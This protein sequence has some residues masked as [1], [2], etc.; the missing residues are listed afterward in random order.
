VAIT[1]QVRARLGLPDTVTTLTPNDAIR[2]I[3][4]APVDLLWNGGIGTYVKATDERHADVGDKTNDALR[5]DAPELRCRVVAEGGNLGLTQAARVEYALDEGRVNTDFIDNSGGVDASDH[6]VNI[7]IV[8]DAAVRNGNLTHDERDRLLLEMTDDVTALVLRT[9]YRQNRAI[10]NSASQ[11]PSMEDVHARYIRELEHDGILDRALESLPD[12]EAL[13]NRRSAG[14]GLTA[15]ELA[16][17]LSYSKIALDEQIRA[18]DVPDD[19]DFVE[20]LVGYFPPAMRDQFRAE[21]GAHPLR[22]GIVSTELVNRLVNAAGITFVFRMEEET[23]APIADIVR[24]HRVARVIFDL[25]GTWSEIEALDNVVPAEVQTDMYLES[26]KLTE[27]ASRWL[28][29][30]RR[31]PLPVR[32]TLDFFGPGVRVV[33]QDLPA[34]LGQAETSRM[35][36][37]VARLLEA[38]VPETLARK[39]ASLEPLYGSLDI[40]DLA[41][42]AGLDVERVGAVYYSLGERLHLDWLTE[43]ILALPRDDRWRTLARTAL[44]D[45]AQAVHRELTSD[46]LAFTPV[47]ADP[48][49]AYNQWLAANE[50]GARRALAVVEEIRGHGADDLPTLT[51]AL[52][53]LRN[54]AQPG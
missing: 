23:G 27:R 33:S 12:D 45:D 39:V 1:P 25:P 13:A 19:P 5:L 2:S 37:R 42:R 3:L 15:P 43:R 47:L 38:G 7:K 36:E 9:N 8:L 48:E 16:V 29:R 22:R 4:A 41:L 51:V 10:A 53:E 11:A 26:R 40:V 52:R 34:L 14:L 31:R 20:E 54:L 30:H 28:L 44:R 32:T 24:A 18:G 46:V 6:E 17:L 21:I 50:N 49:D 35:H